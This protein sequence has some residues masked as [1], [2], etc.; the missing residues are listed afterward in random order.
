MLSVTAIAREVVPCKLKQGAEETYA[1][2]LFKE[3]S[4]EAAHNAFLDLAKNGSAN[5]QLQVAQNYYL[6]VG[7]APNRDQA[8]HW[9]E[10]AFSGGR[11]AQAAR[12]VG[13]LHL[14]SYGDT[15]TGVRW[16]LIAGVEG[17]RSAFNVL[18]H[19]FTQGLG[20]EKDQCLASYFLRKGSDKSKET[21]EQIRKLSRACAAR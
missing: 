11:R 4:V 6:G 7:V 5:A 9:G 20:I 1:W 3:G 19:V 16:L 21:E 8:R 15:P 14:T 17:D 10:T 18:A 2:C 12:L 13:E